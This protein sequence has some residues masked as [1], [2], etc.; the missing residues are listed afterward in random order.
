[1]KPITAMWTVALQ[2]SWAVACW[3]RNYD[4]DDA[5]AP[6]VRLER[7]VSATVDV[8]SIT[9]WSPRYRHVLAS[10]PKGEA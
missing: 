4:T 5:V 1:M 2:R 9:S 10:A 8:V 3:A 7:H 6:N